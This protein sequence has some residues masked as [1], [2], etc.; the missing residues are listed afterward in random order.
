ME[1]G[2]RAGAILKADKNEVHLLGFGVYEGDHVPDEGWLHDIG[3]PNPKIKLDDGRVVWG[4]Q[5]WWDSEEKT[6]D[7]IGDR[8]IVDAT[9]GN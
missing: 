2:Q 5:C 6:K 9:V 4:Y 3:V 7:M 8:K 1:I